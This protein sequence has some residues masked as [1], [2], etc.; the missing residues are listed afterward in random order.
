MSKT[1]LI[2]GGTGLVGS[3]L[4]TQL[5]KTGHQVRLLSRAKQKDAKPPIFQWDYKND[6]LEEGAFDGVDTIVHLAGA[7]VADQRWTKARK[8]E[9]LNSRTQTSNLLYEKLKENPNGVKT[10]VAASA[11][12]YY[13]MDTGDTRL[14]ENSPA[15]N[16]YLA[17]VVD[18]WE[19]STSKFSALGIRVVQLRIGV[20]LSKKG[21]ALT[22]LL[23]PPVSAPLASGQQ[24]MSWV[25]I[26][27]LVGIILKSIENDAM[28][29]VYNAVAPNPLTNKDFTKLTAKAF[30]KVYLPISVPKFVLKLMLGEMA[31]VVVG[32]NLVSADRI[33]KEG[34]KFEFDKLA[35][36]LE[37][38]SRK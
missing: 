6:F 11:I 22:K 28:N 1:V 21:G 37:V 20:V 8:E 4:V 29:G 36:A 14:D 35:P 7:G 38:L 23:E 2:T 27:D 24:Y 17:H 10:I 34:Y 5:H 13:G 12:G 32:G 30:G 15:G 25:H 31:G 18:A 3:E 26:N 16:D 33:V 19:A 9:I